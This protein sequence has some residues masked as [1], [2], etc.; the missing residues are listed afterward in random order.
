[1]K[2]FPPSYSYTTNADGKVVAVP[3]Y[4]ADGKETRRHT[5]TRPPF[6]RL[7]SIKKKSLPARYLLNAKDGDYASECCLVDYIST[8]IKLMAGSQR[9]KIDLKGGK[10]EAIAKIA[11]WETLKDDKPLSQQKCA[12]LLDI[13]KSSYQESWVEKVDMVIRWVK[14]WESET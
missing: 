2:V 3:K 6:S 14:G 7:N 12:D 4:L 11:L 8:N 1:M 5:G 10:S 13:H 9:W